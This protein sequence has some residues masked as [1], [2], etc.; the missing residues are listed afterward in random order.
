LKRIG[1]SGHHFLIP[2]FIIAIL[3]VVVVV[4]INYPLSADLGFSRLEVRRGA[5]L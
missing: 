3:V 5:S 1:D 2:T 4:I